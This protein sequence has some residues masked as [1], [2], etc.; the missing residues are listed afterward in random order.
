VAKP[1]SVLLHQPA[2]CVRIL[3][4]VALG[5]E[6]ESVLRY[7]AGLAKACA[8]E[9]LIVHAVPE[10]SEAMLMV[11]GLDDSGEIELLPQA[12][13]RRICSMAASLD[14]PYRVEAKIGDVAGIVRRFAKQWHADLVVVGRGRTTDRWQFG[15]NVGDIIARSPCPVITVSGGAS[16]I[17]RPAKKAGRLTTFPEA[18]RGGACIS[19]VPREIAV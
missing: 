8:G 15:A 19:D 18:L 9:L 11:Y 16:V 2:R 4:G 12:A 6:G 5:A 7:A 17:R 1:K 14:V 3:C 10:I 13:R